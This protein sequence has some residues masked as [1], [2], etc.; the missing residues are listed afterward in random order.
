MF[1]W[2]LFV[3][4]CSNLLGVF[5]TPNTDSSRNVWIYYDGH[6][7]PVLVFLVEKAKETLSS[8]WNVHFLTA[9]TIPHYLKRSTFPMNYNLYSPQAQSDFIRLSL[10]SEYGGW[11]LDVSTILNSDSFMENALRQ[12]KRAHAVFYGYCMQCPR[13]LI[14][15]GVFYA[16]K[17]SIF[18]HIWKNEYRKALEIGRIH[19]MYQTFR[20]NINLPA[21]N[22]IRYPIVNP[23][24]TVYTAEQVALSRIPR[25]TPLIIHNSETAIYKLLNDCRWDLNCGVAALRNELFVPRY[26]I[27]K[28]WSWWRREAWPGAEA[29]FKGDNNDLPLLSQ[30]CHIYPNNPNGFIFHLL[31]TILIPPVF[32]LSYVSLFR[33]LE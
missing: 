8:R 24:F 20:S 23:Y 17:D 10:I 28:V 31:F 9:E 16:P 29:K 1:M 5:L 27:T 33:F 22:F 14:E 26:Q 11:W 2:I 15:S 21:N 3:L 13:L 32:Y 18:I 25:R 12:V 6:M 30:G 7:V 19:Y 4:M